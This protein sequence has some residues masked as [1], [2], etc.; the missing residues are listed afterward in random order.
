MGAFDFAK[1]IAVLGVILFHMRNRYRYQELPFLIPLYVFLLVIGSGLMPMFF[2]ISGYGFKEKKQTVILKK[3]F[4]SMIVPYLVSIPIVA[5]LFLLTSYP[6]FY[7][8]DR[9]WDR[10]WGLMSGLALGMPENKMVGDF[11]IW[12][13]VTMWFFIA[14]FIAQNML[15]TIA[16]VKKTP[17]QLVLVAGC[18]LAGMALKTL[19]IGYFCI[20]QG[21]MAVGFCYLGYAIKRWK[22]LDRM[23]FAPWVWIMLALLYL[24]QLFNGGFNMASGDYNIFDYLS[25]GCGGVLILFLA[26]WCNRLEGRL[27][28]GIRKVGIQSF[29]II[30]THGIERLA[31][32]WDQMAE[33]NPWPILAFIIEVC[34][35]VIIFMIGCMIFRKIAQINYNRKKLPRA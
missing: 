8:R 30:Y 3:T 15:N 18:V 21:L 31:L 33:A 25:A 11:E 22:L 4:S 10:F 23:Y 28:D 17:V 19:D 1:G 32:P 12:A 24:P 35:K 29:W 27:V 20:P 14:L 6:A 5:A 26:L 9:L 16:K 13:I 7:P 2:I 34:M